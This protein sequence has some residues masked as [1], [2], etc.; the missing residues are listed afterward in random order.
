MDLISLKTLFIFAVFIFAY[1]IIP[2]KFQWILLLISSLLYYFLGNG[3]YLVFLLVTSTTI[4]FAAKWLERITLE[5]QSQQRD[6]SR[7]EKKKARQ[8][9]D[10][11]KKRVVTLTL[12]V[13]FGV[14]GYFKYTNYFIN[15]AS[16]LLP[17]FE[18]N[19]LVLILPLGISFYTFQAVGYLIDVYR[20]KIKAE[21]SYPKLLLFLS[22]L[23]QLVQGPIGRYDDLAPQLLAEKNFSFDNLKNGAFLV[24]WGFYKKLVIAEGLAMIVNPILEN[25]VTYSGLYIFIAIFLYSIQI[26]GDFSGGIDIVT[27]LSEMMGIRLAEN[28]NRPFFATSLSNFWQR[29]HMTLGSWMRDYVFYPIAFS[30]SFAKFNKRLKSVKYRKVSRV[31]P[32][33]VA[34]MIVFLF[35]GIWHGSSFKYVA[36]GLYNGIIITGSLLLQDKYTVWATRIGINTRTFDWKIFQIIRTLFLTT[37]GR[38]FTRGTSFKNA[39]SLYRATF[40][41]FN[42]WIIIDNSFLEFGLSQKKLNILFLGILGLFLVELLQEKGINIRKKIDDSNGVFQILLFVILLMI[43]LLFGHYGESVDTSNFIYQG[44]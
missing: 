10:K 38:Y 14:L 25:H 12:L 44:F 23:P 36:F 8:I 16:S 40:T 3:F 9:N 19:P 37:I 6:L 35:V 32:S 13:N 33:A 26:Y 30:P 22:Y 43:I 17:S 2:K 18:K 42:P 5:S 4:F 1:F 31:L 24:L 20:G 21:T 34:S 15:L 7:E 41:K 39:L 29:W 27:G 28:F 11:K